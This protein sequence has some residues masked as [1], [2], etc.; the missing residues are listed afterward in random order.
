MGV[1]FRCYRKI[2]LELNK[3][4]NLGK[5]PSKSCRKRSKTVG[6][7]LKESKILL[8]HQL[9]ITSGKKFETWDKVQYAPQ[10]CLV[11]QLCSLNLHEVNCNIFNLNR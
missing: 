10:N 5:S 6:N 3:N 4:E 9:N 8:F 7:K 1:L 2:Y 11:F